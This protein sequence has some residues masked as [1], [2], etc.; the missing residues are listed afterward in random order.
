MMISGS[1]SV[2]QDRIVQLF[3]LHVIIRILI[4]S[5][6]LNRLRTT[7]LATL[8]ENFLRR[9]FFERIFYFFLHSEY[10]YSTLKK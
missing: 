7:K 8:G 2:G 9:I 4:S 5:W 3:E 10:E 6:H 1:V